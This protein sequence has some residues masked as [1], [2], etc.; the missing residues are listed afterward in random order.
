MNEACM[1]DVFLTSQQVGNEADPAL[2]ISEILENQI[3]VGCVSKV[4]VSLMILLSL[5]SR[6][7][8][9]RAPA[10]CLGGHGFESYWELRFFSMS[11]VILINSPFIKH[12]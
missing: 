11:Y 7:S 8:V 12:F 1:V 10:R 9:D 2:E 6:C 3:L 4:E 5:S